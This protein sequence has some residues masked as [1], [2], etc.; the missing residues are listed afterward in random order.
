MG[1]SILRM[2]SCLLPGQGGRP[3]PLVGRLLGMAV[4]QKALFQ[5]VLD[6]DKAKP[7]H[8]Y[9]ICREVRCDGVV[10]SNTDQYFTFPLAW[11]KKEFPFRFL[12][13]TSQDALPQLHK[14]Q[15]R[16]TDIHRD[17]RGIT[18]AFPPAVTVLEQRRNV[19]L[20]LQRRHMPKLSVWGLPGKDERQTSFLRQRLILELDNKKDDVARAMRNVSAGGMRLSLPRH[21]YAQHGQ[22]L[23]PGSLLLLQLTFPGLDP[24]EEHA[25]T[26][27]ARINNTLTDETG[28][29][30]QFGVQFLS[31]RVKTPQPH[32]RDV[33]REGEPELFRLLHA[34]QLDYYRELKKTLIM[35]EEP[36]DPKRRAIY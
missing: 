31:S 15:A 8:L 17:L 36:T 7:R 32:W 25:F 9:L 19:R 22:W 28:T 27:V 26:F 24:F 13:Q 20:M 34:Y 4:A 29:N 3:D 12:I 14:F 23:T 2:L 11:R 6:R 21:I 16:I 10:L 18:V 5:M 33:R 35:R 1:G 30:P